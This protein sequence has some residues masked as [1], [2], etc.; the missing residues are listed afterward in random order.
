VIWI[1]R[2][3]IKKKILTQG[4]YRRMISEGYAPPG[5]VEVARMG[6]DTWA[7]AIALCKEEITEGDAGAG[8]AEEDIRDVI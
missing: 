7:K 8:G 5:M 6:D 2:L 1:L 4:L 3:T